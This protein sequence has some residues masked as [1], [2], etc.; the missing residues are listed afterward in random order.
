MVDQKRVELSVFDGIPHL[1]SPVVTDPKK[2]AIALRWAVGEM[3][4][5]YEL[6]AEAGVRNIETYQDWSRQGSERNP[7]N[8]SFIVLS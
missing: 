8:T 2:A 1:I 5:R 7:G 3:E 6:F 4:R